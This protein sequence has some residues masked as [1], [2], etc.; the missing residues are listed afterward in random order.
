VFELYDIRCDEP[1]F[2]TFSWGNEV[3]VYGEH[4]RDLV[5]GNNSASVSLTVP[6]FANTTVD[7]AT[8]D[9]T[10]M[11][12][13]FDVSQTVD[14]HVSKLF[15]NGAFG[16]V[17]P[18][19]DQVF[20]PPADCQLSFK[21][22][23]ELLAKVSNLVIT[24][25]GVVVTPPPG[26][27][28]AGDVVTGAKGQ[29]VDLHYKIVLAASGALTVT[30]Q[31][32]THCYEPCDH[33]FAQTTTVSR[34]AAEDPHV[35]FISD[36]LSNSITREVWADAD[37]K[38]VDW[39]FQNLALVG[40]GHYKVLVPPSEKAYA[41]SKEVIHNNGP[42]TPVDVAKTITAT[43]GTG[44]SVSYNVSGNETTING[45]PPPAPG[46]EIEVTH[47]SIEVVWAIND[48]NMSVDFWQSEL[49]NFQIDEHQWECLVQFDKEL[50]GAQGH[51]RAPGGTARRY[52]TI[53][54]DTDKDGVPDFC[55]GV[56]DNCPLVKNADQ[57]DTDGDGVGD[58]C[59][60][61]HKV[62]IKYCLK[63]GP[64]PVNISDDTGRYMWTICEIGNH[65]TL[66]EVVDISL[67]VSGVP[68]GCEEMLQQQ[69]L[70][71]QARFTLPAGEQKFLLWRN[72]FECHDP[73]DE[74]LHP[75]TVTACVDAEQQ[76]VDHDGD[77]VAANDDLDGVDDNADS[78][79][80][81]DPPEADP[82][83]DC[84]T[85]IRNLIVHIPS[86]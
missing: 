59:D 61:V 75:L 31:W 22:T 24:K 56:R 84:E 4:V 39:Y 73:A 48:L 16:P 46:N 19:V 34:D 9:M 40:F 10:S 66:N 71:G 42:F 20:T 41:Q 37:L 50:A 54:A 82:P 38:I 79:V 35:S 62:E 53:C 11:P 72:R 44:C 1:S 5:P 49:W 86:P 70:P 14:F 47:G 17:H 15:Q 43:V 28:S 63:F 64:A 83:A 81:N 76:N 77:T 25:G 12:N 29:T 68:A 74:G 58:A 2:H 60:K 78:F 6:V 80:D 85:Q 32:A 33:P 7:V 55:Q 30:E 36:T 21:V 57:K 51:V 3:R 52:V 69:I 23:N 67:D 13:N 65:G 18:K 26:G 8:V 45:S 27:W